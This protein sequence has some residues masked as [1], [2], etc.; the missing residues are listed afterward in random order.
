VAVRSKVYKG[1]A[2]FPILAAVTSATTIPAGKKIYLASDL[3]LGVPDA[4]TS[5]SRE[6]K[7]VRW[8][9][10]IRHDAAEIYILGDVFDFWFEYKTA[11]PK[12]FARIQG[13]LAELTDAGIPITVFAGN[14]DLWYRDYLPNELGVRVIHNFEIRQW[15]GRN[16][17]LAHGD[18]LGPG[19]RTY[20]F[21]KSVFVNP[22]FKW[23]FQFFHPNIGIGLAHFFSRRSASKSR[24]H[25][26]VD[27]GDKEMLYQFACAHA[28]QHPEISYYIFGHRHMLK[29]VPIGQTAEM[30][31]LGEWFSLYSYAAIDEAGVHLHQYEE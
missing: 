6:L 17:Y 12:G 1:H 10:S 7:F 5:R 31:Y 13:K 14:H 23:L 21:T 16:Y 2:A 3:H 9:E 30:I 28:A 8:L 18:G 19:D 11:I 27:Y 20:K 22:F 24:R 29:R 25:D 26:A 15:F 4:A